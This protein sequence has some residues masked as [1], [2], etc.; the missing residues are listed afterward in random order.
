M[1]SSRFYSALAALLFTAVCAWAGSAL[2]GRLDTPAEAG[3][4]PTAEEAA[5]E[6]RGIVLRR[7]TSVSPG[8]EARVDACIDGHRLSAGENPYTGESAVFFSECDGFEYLSPEDAFSLTAD[9]LD[10]LLCSEAEKAAPGQARLVSGYDWYYAAFLD[11]GNVSSAGT[12]R[13]IFD[14]FETPVRALLVH[15]D[16]DS[17]GRTVLLFRLTEGG[18]YLKLRFTDAIIVSS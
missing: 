15:A 3:P 9:G 16:T 8:S 13:L 6:L 14:S 12:Y 17:S 7:E 18:D 10:A 4:Q 1:D 2:F 11:G 5:G